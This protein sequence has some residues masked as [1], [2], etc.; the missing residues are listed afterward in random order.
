MP[1][2]ECTAQKDRSAVCVVEGK[3]SVGSKS[4]VNGTWVFGDRPATQHAGAG[5]G[6]GAPGTGRLEVPRSAV[7]SLEAKC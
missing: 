3:K 4:A 2:G 1:K 5:G 7:C 6:S